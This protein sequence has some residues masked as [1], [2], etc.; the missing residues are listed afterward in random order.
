MQLLKQMN[1]TSTPY[2]RTLMDPIF[3]VVFEVMRAMAETVQVFT[4]IIFHR[5]AACI[6][7]TIVI[8][9]NYYIHIFVASLAVIS[10]CSPSCGPNA[11]CEEGGELPVCVCKPGFHEDGQSCTGQLCSFLEQYSIVLLILCHT[12]LVRYVLLNKGE[13]RNLRAQYNATNN[14]SNSFRFA[15]IDECASPEAND[16]SSK[17]MCTNTEGSYVCRCKWG[18]VGDGK[19]CTGKLS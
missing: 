1:V 13:V 19:N 14:H 11:F 10:G 9:C 17:A 16:C 12:L 4:N 18:Y 2:V 8:Y 15:D 7:A 3:A 5:V 6:D